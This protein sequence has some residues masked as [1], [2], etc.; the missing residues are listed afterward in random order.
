M[1]KWLIAFLIATIVFIHL[2]EGKAPSPIS[3]PPPITKEAPIA[4]KKE[5]VVPHRHTLLFQFNKAVVQDIHAIRAIEAYCSSHECKRI[6]VYGYTDKHGS[7]AYNKALGLERANAVA[8]LLKGHVGGAT[9]HIKSFGED[10]QIHHKDKYN[11]RATID[12]S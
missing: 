1:A 9:I 11:R 2:E 12:I 4:P 7:R 6:D 3:S 5:A 10:N 8:K